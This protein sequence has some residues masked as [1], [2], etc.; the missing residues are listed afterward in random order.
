MKVLK[1]LYFFSYLLI[2]DLFIPCLTSESNLHN[3]TSSLLVNDKD[4]VRVH[5]NSASFVIPT[6]LI[7]LVYDTLEDAKIRFKRLS[8]NQKK[9]MLKGLNG[10]LS[11]VHA[12]LKKRKEEPTKCTIRLIAKF[13][14]NE[15]RRIND[16]TLESQ[17]KEKRSFREH[18]NYWMKIRYDYNSLNKEMYNQLF[19]DK[20]TISKD[21]KWKNL[22]WDKWIY[23]FNK[24]FRKEDKRCRLD[25]ICMMQYGYDYDTIRKHYSKIRVLWEKDMLHMW[26]EWNIF[27][28]NSLKE[29]EKEEEKDDLNKEIRYTQN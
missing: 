8:Y 21:A 9:E 23:S 2:V 18:M 22:V 14:M 13:I 7:D 12:F 15:F 17:K 20:E 29:L 26:S 5:A 11:I 24:Y 10:T 27:L 19:N 4:L 6:N 16:R 3:H 28:N 1:V 25:F